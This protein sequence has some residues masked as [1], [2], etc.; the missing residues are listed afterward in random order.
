QELLTRLASIDQP[1]QALLNVASATDLFEA[2]YQDFALLR[3]SVAANASVPEEVDRLASLVRWLIQELNQW[4]PD[5]DRASNRLAALIVVSQACDQ[6]NQLWAML[7]DSIGQNVALLDA[8]TAMIN[9]LAVQFTS[10]GSNVP[11]WEREAVDA[12]IKAEGAEDWA[13]IGER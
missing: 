4:R 1:I 10:R 6:N 13:E 8:L 5:S 7:P 9:S 11:I 12:L 3:G 2:L